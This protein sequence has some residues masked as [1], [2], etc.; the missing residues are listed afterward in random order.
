MDENAPAPL[1]VADADIFAGRI[2]PGIRAMRAHLGC[3]LNEALLAF[4]ARYE[5]LRL[6]QPD[7]FTVSADEY[8]AGFIS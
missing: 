4:H 6:E 8:W 5:V 1:T 2:L 7:T 3:P